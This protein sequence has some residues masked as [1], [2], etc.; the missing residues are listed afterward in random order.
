MRYESCKSCR[1]YD[2]PSIFSQYTNYCRY[3]DRYMCK[4]ESC[5]SFRKTPSFL[6]R[7]AI[8]FKMLFLGW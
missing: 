5:A 7:I 3:S 8:R 6:K 2:D 4:G 1:Y